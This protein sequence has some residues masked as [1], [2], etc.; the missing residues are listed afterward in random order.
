MGVGLTSLTTLM[1]IQLF[2][3]LDRISNSCGASG[4]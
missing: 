3:D 2:C 1:S 4:K